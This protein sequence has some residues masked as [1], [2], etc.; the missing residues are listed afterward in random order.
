[1]IHIPTE[2]K[3]SIPIQILNQL[4]NKAVND[5]CAHVQK[6]MRHHSGQKQTQATCRYEFAMLE[7]I[8]CM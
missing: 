1:M 4:I 2:V 7:Y 3:T 5:V 6:S 8:L